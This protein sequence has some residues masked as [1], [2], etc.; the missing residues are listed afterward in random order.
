MKT[1]L[2]VAH[3]ATLLPRSAPATMPP[4]EP[5]R[6]PSPGTYSYR[7][8]V[9]NRTVNDSLVVSPADGGQQVLT[10]SLDGHTERQIVDWSASGR[11]VVESDGSDDDGCRWTPGF[12]TMPW[13]LTVGQTWHVES[14]CQTGHGGVEQEQDAKVTGRARWRLDDGTE[15]QTWVISRQT[16]V[17]QHFGSTTATSFAR[18]S[19]LFAPALGLVVSYTS[20][21]ETPSGNGSS[22]TDVIA[23][24]V[25]GTPR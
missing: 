19:E 15:V 17:T 11:T 12:L 22:V 4:T 2:P 3:G 25:S 16:R 6:P 1:K 24:L 21:A 20:R 7:Y 5:L 13:P 23:T 18:S 8:N 10:D 9:D 14:S